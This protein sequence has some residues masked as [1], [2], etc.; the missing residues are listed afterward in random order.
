MTS[1]RVASCA[2]ALL[3]PGCFAPPVLLETR[4]GALD[5]ALFPPGAELVELPVAPGES[6]RG[7]FVPAMA[8]AGPAIVVLDFQPSSV[9]LLDGARA[10]GWKAGVTTG[11]VDVP[12]LDECGGEGAPPE[13]EGRMFPLAHR[14]LAHL[15]LLGFSVL[16]MDYAGV[17]ASDGERS[18]DNLRRDAH[19]AWDEAVRRAGGDP[20]RVVLRGTSLGAL[21]VAALLQDG[22]R[23]AAVMLVAPVRDET[24]TRNGARAL[25]R[26]WMERLFGWLLRAPVGVDLLAELTAAHAPALVVVPRVDLFL[27][28]DE[29]AAL[30]DAVAAACGTFL[31]RH[32]QHIA[33]ALASRSLLD[34]EAWFL[35][36]L[37]GLGT[38]EDRLA[39]ELAV[40]SDTRNGAV[41]AGIDAADGDAASALRPGAPA[42]RRLEALL[43]EL[44]LALP[45]V[46]GALALAGVSATER[47]ELLEVLEWL[48]P[49]RRARLDAGALRRLF[50]CDDPAGRLDLETLAMLR[51]ARTD[52]GQLDS[53]GIVAVFEDARRPGPV[54]EFGFSASVDGSFTTHGDMGP[55]GIRYELAELA[56]AGLAP[57]DAERQVLRLLLKAGGVPERVVAGSDGVPSIEVLDAGGWRR[58]PLP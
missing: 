28:H 35:A 10:T 16:V 53:D 17:G 4:R 1:A 56:T 20:A 55:Q 42:R 44:P 32:N 25:G 38:P 45:G 9:T 12:L 36:R 13:S 46:A 8:H 15:P 37:P 43:A 58:L 31:V 18:A 52:L 24:V 40:W 48:P 3:L 19:V 14:R 54:E 47:R 21:A 30:R 6:L 11:G 33:L 23:P 50:D 41:A 22:A 49:G 29:R 2:L 5:P 34:V 7:V 26:P 39:A 51:G 57:P 27:R